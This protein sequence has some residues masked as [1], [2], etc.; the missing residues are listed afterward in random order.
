MAV[1]VDVKE[2]TLIT[3]N[4]FVS[5]LETSGTIEKLRN[6][7]YSSEVMSCVATQLRALAAN[8]AHIFSIIIEELE[9]TDHFQSQNYGQAQGFVL[10]TTPWY[11]IRLMLWIPP[12]H[13]ASAIPFSYK[14]AHDHA[15]DLMTVGFFGPGY[16]TSLYEFDYNEPIQRTDGLTQLSY[17]GEMYL[18]EN[19]VI[20]YFANKDVHIQH[21][22]ESLSVSL[23]LIINKPDASAR[24][25]VFD[26]ES[27]DEGSNLC[28]GKPHFNSIEKIA[29]QRSIFSALSTHGNM[30]SKK[31]IEKIAHNHKADE[32]RALSWVA[33]LRAND[34]VLSDVL[35][36]EKSHY[37]R[38]VLA[39]I[40]MAQGETSNSPK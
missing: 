32:V 17:K 37:V 13:Q 24:Q 11:T 15:F 8:K 10:Y 29:S 23:N 3:L 34:T 18:R 33:M 26:I 39:E 1:K 7:I 31:A 27:T 16:R 40:N 4:E 20:Y 28:W 9:K 25:T 12:G 30:R 38:R 5:F 22:P 2:N 36:L 6:S 14:V 21:E 19:E 35:T